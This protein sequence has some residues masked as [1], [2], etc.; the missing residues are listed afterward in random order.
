M[1]RK[2][3]ALLGIPIDTFDMDQTVAR[4]FDL[5][6]AFAT[7]RRPRLVAT[8]NVDFL[9][10]T[11]SWRP[12]ANRHPELGAI[13]RRAA[14]VTPD[15]MPI[16]W[17][18]RL[19]GAAFKERVAGADLVPRLAAAAAERG[20]SI[21]FLGGAGDI[22]RQAAERLL[23]RWPR[24]QVAG[25][26]AP[27][28][29]TEGGEIEES[30]AAD[31]PIVERINRSGADILLVAFGNP[32][33]EIWFERN[34]HRLQ[35]PVAIGIGGTYEF[36]VGRVKRA[37]AWIQKAGLEWVFR[38][39]QDP[40]RLW[41]RY[42]VGIF[43]FGAMLLPGLLLYRLNRL[44]PAGS[45]PAALPDTDRPVVVLPPVLDA[46]AV[47]RDGE[48]L[49]TAPGAVLDFSRVVRMDA[50][51]LGLLIDRWRAAPPGAPPLAAVGLRP[52]I[53]RF[54]H[55]NRVLDLFEDRIYER[56]EQVPRAAA[57]ASPAP[58]YRRV[59]VPG[60]H[61]QLQLSGTLDVARLA[62]FDWEALFRTVGNADCIL[63][64]SDLRFVDSTGLTFFLKLRRHVTG[65]GRTCV[66]C[67]VPPAVDRMLHVTRLQKLFETAADPA[68]AVERLGNRPST[69]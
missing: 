55:W 42:L 52:S 16:V 58:L 30:A 67:R 59:A 64:L 7:E 68:A 34:R 49:R 4:I 5:V 14:L 29:R 54:L 21:Y 43:K 56:L 6:E 62:G 32:K 61:V 41:K 33:Q 35:V 46:A 51:G 40:A 44:R 27:F 48:A 10:N 23:Q 11:L 66:L 31:R 39:T 9:V 19:L 20:R 53:R 28:V 38:I 3:C 17:A 12:G 18:G 60:A 50:V 69:P 26:D 13:L 65:Q 15:G 2:T 37:P 25:V 47:D 8:V 63:D 45:Q 24:L 22:G 57:A 1:H 36:I